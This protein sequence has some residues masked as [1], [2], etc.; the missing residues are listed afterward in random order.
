MSAGGEQAWRGWV[1]NDSRTPPHQFVAAHEGNHTVTRTQVLA[2]SSRGGRSARLRAGLAMVTTALVGG[3]FALGPAVAAQEAAVDPEPADVAKQATYI[4]SLGNAAPDTLTAAFP[5]QVV[6]LVAPDFCTEEAEQISGPINEQLQSNP[7]EDV[8]PPEPQAFA[9]EGSL[10]AATYAGEEKYASALQI[11]L[12]DVPEGDEVSEFQLVLTES[13]DFTFHSDSPFFREAIFQAIKFGGGNRTEEGFED[14]MEAFQEAVTDED[15]FSDRHLGVEACP[16]IDDWEGGQNQDA[17]EAP[18]RDIP[19]RVTQDGE[20]TTLEPQLDCGF[21]AT[22]Q[23]QDDGTWVFDLTFAAEAWTAGDMENRGVFL[24][25]LAAENLAYGDPDPSTFDQVTFH[26]KDAD[27]EQRPGIV[28]ATE[29]AP[30]L[31][32]FDD[33]SSAGPASSGSLTPSAPRAGTETFTETFGGLDAAQTP[34]DSRP[35]VEPAP[36]EPP[37]QAAPAGLTSEPI[38]EWWVWLLLPLGLAGTWL[39]SQALTAEPR[40]AVERAGAM[41]RLIEARRAASP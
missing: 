34:V 4:Y 10:P 32:T 13:S 39:V 21:G 38:T 35:A 11:D 31:V 28:F 22:G 9:P 24:R 5:P 16:I 33:F 37:R 29:P 15:K 23:R 40:L 18:D 6:C 8:V 26:G 41:T 20:E 2:R 3:V 12:P 36:Q 14:F 19:E 30:D 1:S 7:P 27:E 17:A 25:P